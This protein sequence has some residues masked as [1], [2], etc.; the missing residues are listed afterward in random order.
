MDIERQSEQDAENYER[1]QM[2]WPYILWAHQP[3][4]WHPSPFPELCDDRTAGREWLYTVDLYGKKDMCALEVSPEVLRGFSPWIS[5]THSW[6]HDSCFSEIRNVSCDVW[7][8]LDKLCFGFLL[9][10]LVTFTRVENAE[11]TVLS[12]FHCPPYSIFNPQEPMNAWTDWYR[13]HWWVDR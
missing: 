1:R 11:L 12:M 3:L 4:S 10:L 13:C 6:R 9:S 2:G 7:V 5:L 8:L